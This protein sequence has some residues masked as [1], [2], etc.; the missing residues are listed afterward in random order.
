MLSIQES[1][2][3]LVPMWP[4]VDGRSVTPGMSPALH[5]SA[6]SN[7]S[8]GTYPFF[9][10]IQ[11]TIHIDV[12]AACSVVCLF[13][14]AEL[15]VLTPVAVAVDG[16]VVLPVVTRWRQCFQTSGNRRQWKAAM[17]MPCPHTNR[18]NTIWK[19]ANFQKNVSWYK[20]IISFISF[21]PGCTF[22]CAHKRF[23]MQINFFL[24]LIFTY[25]KLYESYQELMKLLPK[26]M[27]Q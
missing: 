1:W 21:A 9:S 18:M 16:N 13:S 20:F 19:R 3:V 24:S 5:Y 8:L 22:Q 23:H 6:Y 10:P 26:E 17:K 4:R 7:W 25:T 15:R 11:G 14:A 2:L 12:F 27:S